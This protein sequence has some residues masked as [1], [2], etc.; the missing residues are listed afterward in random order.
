MIMKIILY[1]R[2]DPVPSDTVGGVR[3]VEVI[4]VTPLKLCSHYQIALNSVHTYGTVI[5]ARVL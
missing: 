5:S 1:Q 4:L 2:G 3:S